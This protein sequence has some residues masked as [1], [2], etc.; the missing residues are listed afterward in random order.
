MLLEDAKRL[1]YKKCYLETVERMWQANSLYQKMGF[2]KL[3][4]QM[5]DTGHG[6]CEV[7]YACEL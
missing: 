5:G 1:G 4:A 6:A 2:K 3:E 7:F